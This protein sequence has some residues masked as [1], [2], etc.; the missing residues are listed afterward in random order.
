V[1]KQHNGGATGKMWHAYR[2]MYGSSRTFRVFDRWQCQRPYKPPVSSCDETYVSCSG[3]AD[4]FLIRCICI[5]DEA[6]SQ[7]CTCRSISVAALATVLGDK[8]PGA[9]AEDKV[10]PGIQATIYWML[11]SGHL[12]SWI[13]DSYIFRASALIM[14]TSALHT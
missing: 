13:S 4:R 5:A 12:A 6:G 3:V 14:Q 8:Q 11:A 9:E 1:K 7:Q 2:D 10:A